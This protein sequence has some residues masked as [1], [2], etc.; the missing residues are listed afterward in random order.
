MKDIQETWLKYNEYLNGI[1]RTLGGTSNIVGE[2]AEFLVCQYYGGKRLKASNKSADVEGLDGKKYQV[3]ARRVNGNLTTQ[4][5]VIRSWDFDYLVVILFD[6]QGSIKRASEVPVAV[7]KEY[8]KINEYQNGFAITTNRGFLDDPRCRDISSF[9]SKALP[10]VG[11]PE[12]VFAFEPPTVSKKNSMSV[13]MKKSEILKIAKVA[14]KKGVH[15]ANEN[16]TKPVWWL[17]VPKAEVGSIEIP[18]ITFVLCDSPERLLHIME[19]PVKFL[20]ENIQK[21]YPR[22][23]RGKEFYSF[24]LMTTSFNKF[25]NVVP[26]D[27]GLDFSSFLKESIS[28]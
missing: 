1:A 19:I 10:S 9:I 18:V 11:V 20:R 4:L 21:L 8:A 27:S 6:A 15:I 7:A 28:Y 14:S 5:G 3:K 22:F 26:V 25:K 13:N 17:H 24:E 23:S 2:Y 12:S 16:R